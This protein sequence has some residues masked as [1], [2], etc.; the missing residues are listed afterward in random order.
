VRGIRG[1]GNS[2]QTGGFLNMKRAVGR[3]EGMGNF[4]NA[5][6][7]MIGSGMRRFFSDPTL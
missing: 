4:E 5:F 2:E 3:I 1:S 7:S 6:L